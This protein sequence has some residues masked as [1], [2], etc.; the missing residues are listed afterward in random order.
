M[1][2]PFDQDKVLRTEQAQFVLNRFVELLELAG[3]CEVEGRCSPVELKGAFRFPSEGP[4]MSC[5][6]GNQTIFE[7]PYEGED[8]KPGAIVACAICDGGL[9]WPRV[10][11]QRYHA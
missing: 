7:L 1:E 11:V 2:E 8:S 9:H 10:I 4:V 3:G 5:A 6:C